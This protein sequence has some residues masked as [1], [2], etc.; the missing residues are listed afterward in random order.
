MTSRT[1][2]YQRSPAC[3]AGPWRESMATSATSS[4]VTA[5]ARRSRIPGGQF[6]SSRIWTRGSTAMI[7]SPVASPAA[8]P[9]ST[10]AV[11]GPTARGQRSSGDPGVRRR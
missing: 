8:H 11:S 4:T 1:S 5:I 10:E 6:S 7:H 2:W 9:G 3:A